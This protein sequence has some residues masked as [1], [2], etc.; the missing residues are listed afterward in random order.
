MSEISETITELKHGDFV[1][2][3]LNQLVYMVLEDWK[4]E[5]RRFS[6]IKLIEI[7]SLRE[8]L[9]T[10]SNVYRLDLISDTEMIKQHR[11]V[12]SETKEITE[13]RGLMIE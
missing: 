9:I 12:L 7:R 10:K 11:Q 6:Q 1:F 4:D 2:D 13:K 8:T 3:S 5:G